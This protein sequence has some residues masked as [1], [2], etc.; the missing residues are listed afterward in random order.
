MATFVHCSI[1]QKKVD[2]LLAK[3]DT[4]PS[5]GGAG[6]YATVFVDSKPTGGLQPILNFK[7]FN[8]YMHIP[9]FKIPN[10]R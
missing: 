9:N 10:I 7:Q 4:E 6:F 8:C 3:G 5:T 2:E 1:I